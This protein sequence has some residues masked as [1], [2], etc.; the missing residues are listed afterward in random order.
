MLSLVEGSEHDLH[1][2]QVGVGTILGCELY[3][4]I[5]ELE[6]PHLVEPA[7]SVDRAYWGPLADAVEQEYAGKVERLRQ[8]ARELSRPGAWN[9][10]RQ[11]LA[12]LLRSPQD[13]RNC[14]ARA[15]AAWRAE[16]IRC[17]RQRLLGAFVRAHQMRSRFT[18]LDLAH[19]VGVLP[20]AAEEIVETWA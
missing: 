5:M 9:A 7:A 3:R 6:S 19:L 4:R 16:H 8:A 13:V 2:R 11:R 1:G 12:P 15:A 14:L 20:E 18:V 17:D 10:L